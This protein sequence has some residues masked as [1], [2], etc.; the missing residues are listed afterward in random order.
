MQV[1]SVGQQDPLE[2]GMA[3]HCFQSLLSGP[4]VLHQSYLDFPAVFLFQVA[5]PSFEGTHKVWFPLPLPE[6]L[7]PQCGL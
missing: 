7:S 6:C 5:H 4:R 3:T 1:Q 2:E